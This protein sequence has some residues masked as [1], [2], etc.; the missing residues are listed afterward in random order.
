M[1]WNFVPLLSTQARVYASTSSKMLSAERFMFK[2]L[3]N[4]KGPMLLKDKM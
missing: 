4:L 1:L 3:K 2:T